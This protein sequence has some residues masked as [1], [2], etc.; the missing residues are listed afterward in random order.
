M[1]RRTREIESGGGYLSSHLLS[2]TLQPCRLNNISGSWSG[3]DNKVRRKREEK[4]KV[5]D[6]GDRNIKGNKRWSLHFFV[7]LNLGSV[8]LCSFFA[9][10]S[11]S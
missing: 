2:T 9:N 5:N 3:G 10:K 7:Y 4:E 8:T 11:Q 6:R 1:Q